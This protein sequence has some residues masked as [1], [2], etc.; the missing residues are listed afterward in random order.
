MN[1]DDA[2]WLERMKKT[3]AVLIRLTPTT[4]SDFD[5]D[6]ILRC[7]IEREIASIGEAAGK[8]SKELKDEYPRIQW[9]T[10]IGMR[11]ILIHHYW[12]VDGNL[13]WR[14]VQGDI[15]KLEADLGRTQQ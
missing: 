10:I 8:L 5:A 7:C 1:S 14:T 4:Q 9:S 6:P 2:R 11:T 15:P 13:V 3:V 12:A